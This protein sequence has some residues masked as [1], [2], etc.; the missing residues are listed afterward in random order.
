[1]SKVRGIFPFFLAAGLGVGN[2]IWVFG[3]VFQEQQKQKLEKERPEKVLL[4]GLDSVGGENE[5]SAEKPVSAQVEATLVNGSRVVRPLQMVDV[6]RQAEAKAE[7]SAGT[8]T[9]A[10]TPAIKDEATEL[11]GQK[12]DTDAS[13]KSI[14]SSLGF[15]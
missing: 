2:S 12:K 7:G 11:S 4:L 14:W 3:P 5:K 9:G 13:G 15:R 10:E 6:R 8:G 1:M